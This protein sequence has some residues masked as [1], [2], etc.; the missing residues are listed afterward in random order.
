MS[1]I[2]LKE[3]KN[4]FKTQYSSNESWKTLYENIINDPNFL[5]AYLVLPVK[6][7]DCKMLRSSATPFC[8]IQLTDIISP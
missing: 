8:V 2:T 6:R 4:N 5:R 7:V 1:I 3:L